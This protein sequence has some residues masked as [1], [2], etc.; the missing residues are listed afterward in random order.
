MEEIKMKTRFEE[1][2]FPTSDPNEMNGRYLAE[3]AR[4]EWEEDFL[5][6]TTGELVKVTRYELVMKRGEFLSPDN[7]SSLSFYLQTGD[8]KSVTV[9]NIKRSGLCVELSKDAIWKLIVSGSDNKKHKYILF[10]QSLDQALRISKDYLEQ[11]LDG[12]FK[13]ESAARFSSCI[14]I[15]DDGLR[16]IAVDIEGN[17]VT[18]SAI[19]TKTDFYNIT[20]TVK[21]KDITQDMTWLVMATSVDDAKIK[22]HRY[23]DNLIQDDNAKKQWEGY[24][25]TVLS[26]T[27]SSVDI[28]IPKKFSEAYFQWEEADK[29]AH[30]PDKMLKALDKALAQK[31]EQPQE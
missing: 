15:Q 10:A 7:I 14:V 29:I 19:N 6:E 22:I 24:D 18:D 12:P 1:V 9:T 25:I 20:T 3:D 2:S 23:I 27:S 28:V 11:T 16:K 21:T 13:I 4:R 31:T 8:I 26:G 5:D 30:D 17:A